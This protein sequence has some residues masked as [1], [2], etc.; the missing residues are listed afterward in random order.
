MLTKL[1]SFFLE[2]KRIL[3]ITRK[4]DSNEFKSVTKVTGLGMLVIGA[5]GFIVLLISQLLS[6]G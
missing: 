4:P 3:I 2:C 5:I 6:G 1:K